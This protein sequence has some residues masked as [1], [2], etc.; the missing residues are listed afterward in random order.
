MLTDGAADLGLS[1]LRRQH[2]STPCWSCHHLKTFRWHSSLPKHGRDT[3]CVPNNSCK[4]TCHSLPR[5]YAGHFCSPCSLL[6]TW[7]RI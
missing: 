5:V 4:S 7:L 6:R 2:H 1:V 3:R